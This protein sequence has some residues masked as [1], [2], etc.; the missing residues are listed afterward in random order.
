MLEAIG[1]L[2]MGGVTLV[3]VMAADW[4]DE[5]R[6]AGAVKLGPDQTL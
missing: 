4:L 2:I 3:W 5:A 1:W 6:E